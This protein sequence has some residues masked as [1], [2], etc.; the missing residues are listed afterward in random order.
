M[1]RSFLSRFTLA[2]IE[3]KGRRLGAPIVEFPAK[4]ISVAGDDINVGYALE[5][6]F[7][8]WLAKWLLPVSA[9]YLPLPPD[10]YGVL[11][12]PG[13]KRA[14]VESGLFKNLPPGLYKLQYVD[15]RTRFDSASPVSETTRDHRNLTLEVILHYRVTDPIEVLD[16]IDHPV[17]TLFGDV[18]DGLKQ[19]IRTHNHNDIAD[20]ESSK[21]LSFLTERHKGRLQLSKAFEITGIEIKNITRD[22]IS[23]ETWRNASEQGM[24]KELLAQ[25][26][27]IE[28]L[29]A[30][31]NNALV[32]KAAQAEFD[33][34]EILRQV[35]SKDMELERVREIYQNRHDDMV[36]LMNVVEKILEPGM[37]PRDVSPIKNIIVEL[38][39]AL[40]EDTFNSAPPV[41]SEAKPAPSE[42]PRSSENDKIGKLTNTLL[43]LL[44]PHK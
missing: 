5:W 40:K 2:R 3:S 15:K 41:A 11:I 12:P 43:N 14:R 22:P 25:T 32:K 35:R 38:R 23:V 42:S 18:E 34:Q 27:E 19:Y 39:E 6:L 17:E 20:S 8:E 26:Q 16:K 13:G 44:E 1:V 33:K 36:T 30:E 7:D 28:R 37:Y 10:A 21:L 29:K 9:F 4:T 31:H 24:E